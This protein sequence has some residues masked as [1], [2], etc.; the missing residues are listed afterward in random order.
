MLPP[1]IVRIIIAQYIVP[2]NQ[3]MKNMSICCVFLS[4]YFILKTLC[5]FGNVKAV[6]AMKILN[7]FF[8]YLSGF[9]SV[10]KR[11]VKITM[12]IVFLLFFVAMYFALSAGRT[13]EYY[14]SMYYFEIAIENIKSILGLGFLSAIFFEFT[15]N[16]FTDK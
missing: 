15:F 7:E 9:N 14:L 1:S 11:I 5:V 8:D 12:I 10:S 2:C 16:K 4:I 3:K 13:E 6:M